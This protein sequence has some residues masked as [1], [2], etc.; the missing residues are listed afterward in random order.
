MQAEP[1]SLYSAFLEME[2]YYLAIGMTHD[3]FW[4]GDPYLVHVFR[5]AYDLK[6]EMRNQ[7][8][9][10]QGLYFSKALQVE[11]YNFGQGFSKQKRAPKKYIDRPI[12]ITPLSAA[13][14]RQKVLEE[15][16]KVVAYFNRLAAAWKNKTEG[17]NG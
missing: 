16:K 7:E 4:D 14:K 3:Q 15:R 8:L 9:W 11:L 2:P 10:L 13:E 5:E 1:R 12:R 6:R 17:G